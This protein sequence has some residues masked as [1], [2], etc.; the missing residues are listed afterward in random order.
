MKLKLNKYDFIVNLI[1]NLVF[2]LLI[3]LCKTDHLCYR[4]VFTF[5]FNN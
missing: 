4:W 5:N 3:L 1:E 2:P